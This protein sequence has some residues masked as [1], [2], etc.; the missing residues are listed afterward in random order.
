[1]LR[2]G[3]LFVF[4]AIEI[5]KIVAWTSFSSINR[6]DVQGEPSLLLEIPLLLS[7]SFRNEVLLSGKI[8]NVLASTW[9][10]HLGSD[11]IRSGR[12]WSSMF[13]DHGEGSICVLDDVFDPLD[14]PSV[15]LFDAFALPA[16]SCVNFG[17]T[18]LASVSSSLCR[19]QSTVW[20]AISLRVSSWEFSTLFPFRP[21]QI[22]CLGA[23]TWTLLGTCARAYLIFLSERTYICNRS[24][25]TL[26]RCNQAC[27]RIDVID[28]LY[29]KAVN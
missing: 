14:W 29:N 19:L 10:V 26:V 5:L 11:Q 12:S 28:K 16:T 23:L 2:T 7:F 17:V 24:C 4:L 8:W 22:V 18:V 20:G 6:A 1:M 3:W 27:I 9:Y 13:S 25:I 21:W 15:L